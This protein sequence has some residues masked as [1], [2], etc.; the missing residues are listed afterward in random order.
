M[1]LLLVFNGLFASGSIKGITKVEGTEFEVGEQFMVQYILRS[2]GQQLQ[3]NYR[4]SGDNFGALDLVGKNSGNS[5]SIVNGSISQD[6]T[7]TYYFQ[8]KKSGVFK[9]PGIKFLFNGKEYPCQPKTIKITKQKKDSRISGDLMLQLKP[10]K[11]SVYV[12]EPV[13]VDLQWYSARNTKGFQLEELPKFDGFI[14]KSIP[15]KTQQKIRTI[16]GKKYL[17]NK[18]Y[19]FILTP[20]KPGKIKLPKVT[21]NIYLTSGRGFF[22]QTEAREIS[23]DKITLT[24]KPLPIAPSG[25]IEPVIIGAFKVKT[26]LD[27]K[28]L[29]VN[30]AVTIKITLSGSGNLNTLN[31]LPVNFPSAFETLPPTVKNNVKTTINGINGSK[32]FEFVAIP[33]QPGKFEIPSIKISAFNPKSEKYY[34]LKSE[35]LRINVTGSGTADVNPY[36]SSNGGKDVELQ[37]SDIRY[38]NEVKSLSN[39][40]KSQFT[41]SFFQYL[42]LIIGVLGFGIGTFAFKERPQSKTEV[43]SNK[44][45]KANRV[46]Q[47]YLK[48]AKKEINGDKNKFYELVDESINKYLLAKLMIDQSE[49]KKERITQALQKQNVEDSLIKKTLQ[50]S[51][52]C[53]MARFSPIVLPPS[54][55]YS[56]A[57]NI[58]NDLERQLK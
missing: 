21:G 37:G 32:T 34:S 31:Q 20:I 10:N 7:L 38:L 55:M 2:N 33:R 58:I 57:E 22:T 48:D 46:A 29:N 13:R 50:V 53:K 14:V 39:I 27:K 52:D 16:N 28:E 6:L 24:V 51:N 19:T 41:G 4:I 5:T 1:I 42:F 43:K 23:S 54:E 49:L 17:T 9:I 26:K 35:P 45:A 36:I 25:V 8:S 40:S 12:G 47:K 30:D 56:Q 15:S 18:N 44:K 3:G 11:T